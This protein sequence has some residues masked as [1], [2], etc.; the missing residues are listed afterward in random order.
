MSGA[1][2]HWG[3]SWNCYGPDPLK[4]GKEA[5]TLSDDDVDLEVVSF[6][7]DEVKGELSARCI[8]D[9]V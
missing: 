9:G 2:I 7:D 5:R 3:G 6:S 1:V 8:V 4:K